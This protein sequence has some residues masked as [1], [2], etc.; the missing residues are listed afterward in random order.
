[1]PFRV[2]AEAPPAPAAPVAPHVVGDPADL[3]ALRA[4]AATVDVVTFAH[5][6][7]PPQDLRPVLHAGPARRPA[8]EPVRRPQ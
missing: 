1:M 8:D 6:H 5:G 7:V 2:L 4:F 3:A